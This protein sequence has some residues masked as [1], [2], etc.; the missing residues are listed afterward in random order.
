MTNRPKGVLSIM[1]LTP[2]KEK[3]LHVSSNVLVSRNLK[4]RF[5][6]NATKKGGIELWI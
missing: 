1:A 4:R 3:G 6:K 5:Y 2:R